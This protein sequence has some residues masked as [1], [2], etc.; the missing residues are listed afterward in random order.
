MNSASTFLK[1]AF[2]NAGISFDSFV[3]NLWMNKLLQVLQ[4]SNESRN[5]FFFIQMSKKSSMCDPPL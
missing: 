3:A 5:L 2:V 1:K 4:S